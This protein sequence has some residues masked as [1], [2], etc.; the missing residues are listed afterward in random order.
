MDRRSLLALFHIHR[1]RG[2]ALTFA[3]QSVAREPAAD[4]VYEEARAIRGRID[5]AL[6][7]SRLDPP[8][9]SKR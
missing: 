4:A 1:R 5:A 2:A 9:G 7:A 3:A 6:A 8:S